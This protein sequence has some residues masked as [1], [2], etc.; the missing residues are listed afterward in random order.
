MEYYLQAPGIAGGSKEKAREQAEIIAESDAYL[1]HLALAKVYERLKNYNQA[2]AE[3]KQAV[4]LKPKELPP[5]WNLGNLYIA[6]KQFTKAEK[7]YLQI[8]TQDPKNKIVLYTLGKCY[9]MS[10]NELQK[11]IDYFK[12]FLNHPSKKFQN[13]HSYAYWRMGMTYQRLER[14]DKAIQAYQRAVELNPKNKE[15]Q[16]ALDSLKN[17]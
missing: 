8:Q 12:R 15:A 3:N 9:L 14:V 1:G 16:K 10:G 17:K 4:R 6:L 2:I 11:G 5:L 13:F 7:I